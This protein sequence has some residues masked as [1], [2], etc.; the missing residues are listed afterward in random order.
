MKRN[1]IVAC[2]VIVVLTGLYATQNKDKT[3]TIPTQQEI[4]NSAW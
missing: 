4:N 2:V 3:R 1:L